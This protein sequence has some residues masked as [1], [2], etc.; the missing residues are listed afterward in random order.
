MTYAGKKVLIVGGSAGI[1]RAMAENLARR[2][3]S[4]AIAARRQARID[5]TVETLQSLG[6]PGQRFLGA[7]FDVTDPAA[8]RA[9]A[10]RVLQGLGGLDLLVCNSGHAI[11][12]TADSLPDE[13]FSDLLE[14]NYLGHVYAVRAFLPHF[15]RQKSGH[16]CLVS[17]MLGVFSTWGYGAY[18]A[19]KYAIAGFAEALRQELK[20]DQVGVTLY[21]PPTTRTPGLDEENRHK[22]S[23]VWQLESGNSF[24]KIYDAEPVAAD[25]LRAVARKRFEACMGWDSWF[26]MQ[27]MRHFP[28]LTRW[29]NDHELDKAFRRVE[30]Q[31]LDPDLASRRP[32]Q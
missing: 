13:A 3:A 20:R 29:L 26:V 23:V 2:G 5:E 21:Y 32:M 14:T 15:T 31:G 11:V 24:T 16:I 18:S 7:P 30:A 27:M 19:S 8:V 4:V 6:V 25:I 17:S 12:G 10:E 1:G 28:R 22:P 9:G